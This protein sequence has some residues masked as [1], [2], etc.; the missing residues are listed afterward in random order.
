MARKS[1][2]SSTTVLTLSTLSR[3]GGD[4]VTRQNSDLASSCLTGDR[5]VPGTRNDRCRSIEIIFAKQNLM[6]IL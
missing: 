2:R 4:A 3:T 1:T 6:Q 5:L